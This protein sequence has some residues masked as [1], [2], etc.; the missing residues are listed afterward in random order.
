MST[1]QPIQGEVSIE[2]DLRELP[3]RY[4]PP[5]VN[6]SDHARVHMGDN[7]IYNIHSTDSAKELLDTIITTLQFPEIFNRYNAIEDE[8]EGTCEWVLAKSASSDRLSCFLDWF[9]SDQKLFWFSGK[10]GSG[11]SV[12]M[13]Y[14]F[15][16]LESRETV[17]NALNLSFWFWEAGTSLEKSLNGMLRSLLVQMLTSSHGMKLARERYIVKLRKSYGRRD[18]SAALDNALT[19]MVGQDVGV[20]LVLDGLDES[21]EEARPIWK[22]VQTLLKNHQNLRVCVSSRPES[23][24][25]EIYAV[26]PTLRLEDLNAADIERVIEAEL[27]EDSIVAKLLRNKPKDRGAIR[28]EILISAEG[29]FLWVRL[30]IKSLLIGITNRD[31]IM[32]LQHRLSDLPRDLDQLYTMMLSRNNSDI[33]NYREVASFYLTLILHRPL[34]LLEFWLA[35]N[36]TVRSGLLKLTCGLIDV[37]VVRWEDLTTWIESR[38]GGLLQVTMPSN[39]RSTMEQA[40]RLYLSPNSRNAQAKLV[41][42]IH[43]TAKNYILSTSVGLQL[44]AK[45]TANTVQIREICFQVSLVVNWI[46][47]SEIRRSTLSLVPSSIRQDCDCYNNISLLM[48]TLAKDVC[49]TLHHRRRLA[50][51]KDKKIEIYTLQYPNLFPLSSDGSLD[52]LRLYCRLRWYRVLHELLLIR[53]IPMEHSEATN[54]YFEVVSSQFKLLSGQSAST[55][56][57]LGLALLKRLTELGADV[58]A[59]FSLPSSEETTFLAELF[60]EIYR[61]LQKERC[62]KSDLEIVE[63][64]K[65]RRTCLST[66][67]HGVM[68]IDRT[69]TSLPEETDIECWGTFNIDILVPALSSDEVRFQI[70]GSSRINIVVGYRPHKHH[71]SRCPDELR[72]YHVAETDSENLITQLNIWFLTRYSK[73]YIDT[74]PR[75]KIHMSVGSQRLRECL[76]KIRSYNKERT[77]LNEAL[78]Y[79][80]KTQE[81]IETYRNWLT[82]VCEAT[83]RSYKIYKANTLLAEPWHCET[84]SEDDP[85][86]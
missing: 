31:D 66:N 55:Q 15:R 60:P 1:A 76:D 35:T 80:G 5:A 78:L 75:L 58:T 69:S 40:R 28:E 2:P 38:T 39:Y 29:V 85:S 10:P 49:K 81:Q 4:G 51:I 86:G 17:S 43:K 42:F 20:F 3:H 83:H 13:A 46:F 59:S 84:L 33:S 16:H 64:V 61:W 63:T 19:W 71:G 21:G 54:L 8:H 73:A 37:N 72:Y 22:L 53:Q 65:V 7:I 12:L 6:I 56:R 52:E 9:D 34:S 48:A 82:S 57:T 47:P 18:L 25:R 30:A 67:I 32:K 74:G 36:E 44:L 23:F 62:Y 45:C 14:L 70:S 68:R 11:K 41:G 24:F 50:V 27:F 77:S 79:L 26:S